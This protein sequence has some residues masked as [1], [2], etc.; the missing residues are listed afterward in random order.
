MLG[1][2]VLWCCLGAQ[3]R[4]RPGGM[5][6]LLRIARWSYR[7]CD[8]PNTAISNMTVPMA[9]T[10]LTHGREQNTVT[11]YSETEKRTYMI[12]SLLIRPCKPRLRNPPRSLIISRS[13]RRCARKSFV[14][15]QHHSFTISC[16]TAAIT[17]SLE[18]DSDRR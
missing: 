1:A 3:T 16:M 5:G 7:N 10:P 18:E 6:V 9:G 12:A 11:E 15:P 2:R 14:S 8:I 17:S 4:V 13:P